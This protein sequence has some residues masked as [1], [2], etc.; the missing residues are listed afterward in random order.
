[1]VAILTVTQKRLIAD[2][3]ASGLY[4][5][6]SALLTAALLLAKRHS[7]KALL[8]KAEVEKGLADVAASR[9]NLL[10]P[11]RGSLALPWAVTVTSFADIDAVEID[12]PVGSPFKHVLGSLIKQ[13]KRPANLFRRSYLPP[14]TRL[15]FVW[16]YVCAVRFRP[17]RHE[18]LRVLHSG[19]DVA[20]VHEPEPEELP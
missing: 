3:T 18:L 2:I 17:E 14:A 8:F 7:D 11:P 13:V 1:M 5:D 20:D 15:V 9:V 6:Q 10:P 16:P 4:A 19:I 12:D